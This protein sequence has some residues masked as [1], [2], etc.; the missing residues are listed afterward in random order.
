M[1]GEPDSFTWPNDW[2]NALPAIE[3][4]VRSICVRYR[5]PDADAEDVYQAVRVKVWIA[6]FRPPPKKE[7]IRQ[8]ATIEALTTWAGCVA[9]SAVTRR[10]RKE[11]G[12]QQV[13]TLDPATLPAADVS[14]GGL[15]EYLDLLDDALEREAV[16]LRFVEGC[17]YPEIRARLR[18]SVGKAH[19][20]VKTALQ[21]LRR[22]LTDGDP[23][24]STK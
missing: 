2:E 3:R 20:L 8:F 18:V 22:R 23:D 15:E 9:L 6:T 19:D 16:R 14:G 12:L 24:T 11:A 5:L 10:R 4:R 13:D 17:S 1:A 7:T 21:K